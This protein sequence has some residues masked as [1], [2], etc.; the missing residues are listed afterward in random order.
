MSE[1]CAALPDV[2]LNLGRRRPPI[3]HV[4]QLP[5]PVHLLLGQLP[6]P[7]LCRARQ[8][9]L[10]TSR[11]FNSRNEGSKCVSMTWR[12]MGLAHTANHVIGCRLT[13]ETKKQE[14]KMR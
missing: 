3:I 7:P 14:L 12:A 6:D 11:T 8:K 4:F 13:Q 1:Q 9:M 10:A 2:S 5:V